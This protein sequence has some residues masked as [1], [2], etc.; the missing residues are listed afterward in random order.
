MPLK[1]SPV[2]VVCFGELLWDL[3]PDG[4]LPGGAPMNVAYHLNQLGRNATLISRVGNDEKGR[5]L[6]SILQGYGLDT[7]YVQTDKEHATGIVPAAP[8]EFGEMQYEIVKPVAWDFIARKEENIRLVQEAKYF[9]FGSLAARSRRSKNALLQLLEN[10]NQK[11]LDINLR[12]PHYNKRIITELLDRADIIKMN[13][14]ELE[15]ITGWFTNYKT[16]EER[17]AVIQ[18]RFGIATLVVTLGAN[19]AVL[20]KDGMVFHHPGFKVTVA[21]T[22]GSGDSFL[23]AFISQII[24][25]RSSEETLAFASAVGAFITSKKGGCPPYQPA[26]IPFNLNASAG[27]ITDTHLQPVG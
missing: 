9:V 19:G 10:A 6:V 18:D 14:A 23:A 26:D 22:V 16:V 5:E 8:N 24:E 27:S 21:D 25:Q 7:Q 13:Q 11:V 15:M 20:L 1:S 3:L 17:M 2:E 12:P 4:A